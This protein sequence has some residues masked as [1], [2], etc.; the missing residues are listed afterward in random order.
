[1]PPVHTGAIKALLLWWIKKYPRVLVG[2]LTSCHQFLVK[3]KA[4]GVYLKSGTFKSLFLTLLHFDRQCQCSLHCP[5][6]D[7]NGKAFSFS[8]WNM[9]PAIGFSHGL[10][11]VEVITL[12]SYFL[13]SIYIYIYFNM[14][15]CWI[16][17]NAASASI[18]IIIWLSSSIL[19]MSYH[20]FVLFNVL[21]YSWFTIC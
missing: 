4:T 20:F 10:C 13:E 12:Y 1:M 11:Y 15:G 21:E 9:I 7:L 18:E 17:S 19:L 14:K 8:L 5:F 16:F 6:P 2:L 3:A